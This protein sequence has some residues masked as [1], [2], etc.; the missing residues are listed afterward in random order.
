MTIDADYNEPY[1]PHPGG[2]LDSHRIEASNQTLMRQGAMTADEY[3]RSAIDH[4]DDQLGK[5]YAKAHPEL[6]AAFMQT[7]AIDAGAGVIARAIESVS[8]TL[9]PAG[10]NAESEFPEYFQKP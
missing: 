3:L 5:G 8:S 6:I 4:T 9:G 2:P 7:A 1:L 10:S